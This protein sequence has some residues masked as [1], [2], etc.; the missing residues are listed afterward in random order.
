MPIKHAFVSAKSDGA[1][2]TLVRPSNW[3][4]D[5]T[6]T[7]PYSTA[8]EIVL[9]NGGSVL[10]TGI[11]CD[12]DI[13]FSGTVT[14]WVM[15]ADQSGSCVIDLWKDEFANYP[16]TVA[17]SMIGAGTKPNLSSAAASYNVPPLGWTTTA[18]AG[19]QTLRVNIDSATTVTRVTLSLRVAV[20]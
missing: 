11:F 18:L 3:N 14:G 7:A 20:A 15:L 12:I 13:P 17:D 2:T 1:D 16:P 19:G 5:H 9:E 10:A 6:G 4:A 8:F